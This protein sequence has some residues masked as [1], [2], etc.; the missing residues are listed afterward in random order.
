MEDLEKI[1][2]F[3]EIQN[4]KPKGTCFFKNNFGKNN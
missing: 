4:L 1:R 2:M 3:L